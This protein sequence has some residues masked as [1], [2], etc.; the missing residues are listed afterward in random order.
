MSLEER[1]E[2]IEQGVQHEEEEGDVEDGHE[3]VAGGTETPPDEELDELTQPEL[4]EGDEGGEAEE[5]VED[6]TYTEVAEGDASN[7]LEV[8]GMFTEEELVQ[9]F[10][11]ECCQEMLEIVHGRDDRVRVWNTRPYP[12]RT[13][14]DLEIRT[15]TGGSGGCTGA[16]IGPRVVLTAGHCLYLHAHGGWARSIKVIPGRNG[17]Q[18]PYGSAVGTYFISTKGWVQ[19]RNS[20]YDY[21]VIVLPSNKKLGNTVGWMGL[22]SLSFSSL[23]GLLVNS[24]GYPGDKPT[25]TQWWNA[26]RILS[27]SSRRIYYQIDTAGGQSGSPVWRY[28]NGKRHIIGIHTTG[29]APFNGATRIIKPVFDNLVKW[30]NL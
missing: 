17:S 9:E 29:G 3:P 16:F 21:G 5:I 28:R 8:E 26:N 27:V 18:E 7:P 4:G 24:S 14:C 25:G 23:L 10:G 13:I 1:W 22:A 19:N 12:W 6:E 2:L 20:N 15:K 11:I 30:K